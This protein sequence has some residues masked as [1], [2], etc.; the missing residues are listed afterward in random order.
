MIVQGAGLAPKAGLAVYL[1]ARRV[2]AAQPCSRSGSTRPK[3]RLLNSLICA[4]RAA[5]EA[6]RVAG[7]PCRS[8]DALW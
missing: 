2:G 5:G 8:S 1:E 4:C 7:P 6:S 3:T